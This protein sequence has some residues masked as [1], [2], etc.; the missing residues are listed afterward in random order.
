V[1][2]NFNLSEAIPKIQK[3]Q[4]HKINKYEA[5]EQFN[6]NYPEGEQTPLL[7][8]ND[9]IILSASNSNVVIL[10]DG[11]NI[12]PTNKHFRKYFQSKTKMEKVIAQVRCQWYFSHCFRKEEVIL[13]FD[14]KFE[15]VE[16]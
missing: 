7:E 14:E 15:D 11:N 10:I 5:D 2:F 8:V 13:F 3:I 1:R 12:L 6:K 9:L 16:Y 4:Q